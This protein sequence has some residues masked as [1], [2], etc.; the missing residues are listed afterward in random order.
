M[1]QSPQGGQFSFV[2][3]DPICVVWVFVSLERNQP[4][5]LILDAKLKPFIE[6]LGV[7]LHQSRGDSRPVQWAKLSQVLQR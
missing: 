7:T 2:F 1:A 6:A 4:F 3:G 5:L